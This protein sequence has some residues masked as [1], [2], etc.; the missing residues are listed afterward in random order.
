MLEEG[1]DYLSV[2]VIE[3]CCETIVAH[4]IVFSHFSLKM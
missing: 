2:L 1:L 3:N 4:Q